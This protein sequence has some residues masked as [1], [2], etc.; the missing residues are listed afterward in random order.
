[1]P[2]PLQPYL[3]RQRQQFPEPVLRDLQDLQDLR[4]RQPLAPLEHPLA[5]HGRDIAH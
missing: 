2:A 1:M 5:R 4:L 3:V